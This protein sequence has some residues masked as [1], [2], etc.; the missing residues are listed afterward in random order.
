MWLRNTTAKAAD[1]CVTQIG[2]RLHVQVTNAD[3]VVFAENAPSVTE[4]ARSSRLD[5]G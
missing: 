3:G 1:I 2:T 5:G 4:N